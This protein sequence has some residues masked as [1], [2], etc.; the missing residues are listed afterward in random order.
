MEE[1]IEAVCAGCVGDVF[2]RKRINDKGYTA[3]C[4][5]CEQVGACIDT[6]ALADE[7]A[8]ILH[9][10]Y[11]VDPYIRAISV[12]NLGRYIRAGDPLSLLVAEML[13]CDDSEDV[14]TA[15][16]VEMLTNCSD[17]DLKRGGEPRFD[18]D[19]LYIR[20]NI[21]PTEVEEKWQEFKSGVMHRSRFFNDHGKE[22]LDWLFKDIHQLK[23][24][25][26]KA[27]VCQ[28]EAEDGLEVYRGRYCSPSSDPE[29]I[30]KSP[31][32]E[33][34]APPQD[35]ARAGRMNPFGVPT[36][37]GAFD[38]ETCIAE[39]RP[40]VGGMVLTGKFQVLR[41]VRILDFSV[42][43]NVFDAQPMS[44]FD[45][46]YRMNM[47]RRQFLR[48]LHS[49]I[50]SPVTPDREHE[51]LFTQVI[52]EYLSSQLK[53]SV[54]GVLFAS[55]QKQGG[56]NIALFSS[57]LEGVPYQEKLEDH[58]FIEPGPFPSGVMYIP[59]TLKAHKIGCVT[60]EIEPLHI[61]NGDTI[62]R[63]WRYED[64]PYGDWDY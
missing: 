46:N 26:G 27:V 58:P 53:P 33:L 13:G 20:R 21:R 31:G 30:L 55:V 29:K 37:Y 44:C 19:A 3:L 42:L 7:I 43:E 6:E 39:L 9:T 64:D 35:K 57:V 40:S 48:T 41:D 36:F 49:K 11:R 34:A 22:F 25:N 8:E 38:R 56:K 62:V 52:A 59:S 15:A 10:F 54:D 12:E 47:E 2:L 23:D 63:D 16:I 17:Y 61:V 51:Y 45:P 24:E 14:V 4:S 1:S 18:A 5:A 32:D 50:S 60:F 28:F